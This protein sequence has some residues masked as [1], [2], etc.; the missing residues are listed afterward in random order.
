ME[1]S[2]DIH[3]HRHYAF[4]LKQ[5]VGKYGNGKSYN[6]PQ[7]HIKRQ[8][9]LQDCLPSLVGDGDKW[10]EIVHGEEKNIFYWPY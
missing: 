6:I 4:E 1:E 3:T 7:T 2:D 5:G 9:T 10:I 8:A